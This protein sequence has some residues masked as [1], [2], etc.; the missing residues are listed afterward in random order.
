MSEPALATTG[1]TSQPK[2]WGL[3]LGAL[4]AV[5]VVLSGILLG[6]VLTS[7]NWPLAITA[8]GMGAIILIM[9]AKPPVGLTVWILLAPYAEYIHLKIDLGSGIPDLDISRIAILLLTFRLIAEIATPPKERIGAALRRLPRITWPDIMMIAFVLGILL[10]M[11]PSARRDA[12]G[13]RNIFEFIAIPLLMYYIAPALIYYFARDW[14]QSTPALRMIIGAVALGST[15]L[16]IITIREQLTGHALFSPVAQSL[17]YEGTIRK[18]LSLFGAPA[19]MTTALVVPIPFLLY[20]LLEAR[21]TGRR[22]LLG[23]ALVI[24][25]AGVFFVYVRGGWLGAVL[26]IIAMAALSPNIRCVVLRMLPVVVLVAVLITTIVVAPNVIEKRLASSAPIGYRLIA[27][28]LA[29]ELY[30]TSPVIGIGYDAFNSSAVTQFGWTPHDV[31]GYLPS[32]HNSYLYV[33][34]SGGLLAFVP[35]LG[36]FL[37]LAWRGRVFWRQ[38]TNRE[39]V[40]TLWATLLGYMTI[41]GTV[42]ALNVHYSNILLFLIIGALIGRLE[43]TSGEVLVCE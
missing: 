17:V 29:W 22:L 7:S 30:R 13:I 16:G 9:L 40:A 24:T 25:L 38:P 42:D 18:V 39:L 5:V 6:R 8:V 36:I 4:A 19:I 1:E 11:R 28:K 37:S 35:Y 34:V 43:E 2:S 41:N 20:G 10:S 23:L 26:G 15:L 12:T 31:V 14:L 27:W 32:I 3:A 33:L 21:T